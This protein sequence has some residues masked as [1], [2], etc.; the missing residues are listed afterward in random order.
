MVAG[1]RET[2]LAIAPLLFL[3]ATSVQAVAYV[4]E[5]LQDPSAF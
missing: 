5:F 2:Q 1:D 4:F 3:V